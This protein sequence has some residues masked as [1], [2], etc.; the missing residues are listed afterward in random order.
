VHQLWD[1]IIEPVLEALQPK[2]LVEIGSDQGFNTRNLLGF[3]QRH[4]AVLHVIDP[5]PKYD[6]VAW[7][8]QYGKHL[9]FHKALS[10]DAL[11]TID[12]FDAVLIDGDHNWYTVFNELKLIE[13]RC[14]DSSRDFPLVML[15]DIGW[16]YGRRDLY[17][18]PE[19]IPEEYRKPY[20]HSGLR[21]ESEELV[22]AGGL[23]RNLAN[24]VTENDPR[25]GVLTA[26][27]DFLEE[28]EHV[29]EL[30]QLPGLHGL[31][32]L[33]PSKLKEQNAELAEVLEVLDLPPTVAR[34]IELIEEARLRE[35][36]GRQEQLVR[37]ERLKTRLEK[38]KSK[39]EKEKSK[40]EKEKSKLEKEKSKLEKEKSKL[41]KEKSKLREQK[42]RLEKENKASQIRSKELQQITLHLMER[43]QRLTQ[44]L[45]D[46][47]SSKSWQL[48]STLDRIRAKMRGR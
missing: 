3:C 42:N 41:E 21:P 7:Q 16:P 8:E 25:N 36:I 34:F 40:L 2:T 22:E 10:L 39:P 12:R 5:L 9:V 44:Q 47:Q 27:E 1:T 43:N 6:V 17:Y 23:N 35:D 11:P 30:M 14:K 33:V 20:K 29:I 37:Y 28:T 15:H 46:I 13:G 48:L 4:D 24:A 31:G 26:V 45:E 19:T 18:D 38:E 32:I